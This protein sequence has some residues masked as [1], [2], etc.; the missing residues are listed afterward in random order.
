MGRRI[1]TELAAQCTAWLLALGTW[2]RPAQCAAQTPEPRAS[3]VVTR[4]EGAQD[5]PD[6]AT[7][8]EHVRAVVGA[9]LLRVG[10]GA[11][12]ETWIQVAMARTFAGYT[13]QISSLGVRHG[14]RALED[15]GPSCTSL[16]DAVAVTI[17]IFLDP[18]ANAPAPEP[19]AVVPRRR[20]SEPASASAA[21]S[22]SP[23]HWPQI[24]IEGSGGVALNLVEHSEPL[25]SADFGLRLT[26]RWSLALGGTFV[27]PDT[28]TTSG[29]QVDL[30][31]SYLYLLACA[32]ALGDTDG[33]RADWCAA[34]LLGT[35][36]GSGR[37]YRDS[38]SDRS[39]WLALAVG[40]QVVYPVSHKLA[41]VLAGQGVV[42][43]IRQSF[44]VQSAGVRSNAF[45]SPNVG[46]LI[47]L[48]MRGA[49]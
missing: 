48:G 25:A 4:G 42:P 7:L 11:A 19:V 45:R 27:F 5:C 40:P 28:K 35:F 33:P 13:A 6:A 43:L 36:R 20:P 32:R 22:E 14:T 46:G 18:Y 12:T 30:S 49:W 10:L 1:P 26:P 47:S 29:G 31:L 23:A 9:N 8:A 21:R 34:P 44:E 24:F 2:G 3:L 39:A 38:F 37:G 15:L 41:W 16:A 17:A